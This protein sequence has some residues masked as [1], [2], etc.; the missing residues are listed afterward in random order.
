MLRETLNYRVL[1]KADELV[2]KV[3][4]I[5]NLHGQD[6]DRITKQVKDNELIVTGEKTIVERTEGLGGTFTYCTL[7][8]PIELDAILTGKDLPSYD[9]LGSVLY[10]MATNRTLESSAIRQSD[11]HLGDHGDQHVWLI[12]KPD[13]EWL[14]GPDAALTLGF[15]RKL[16]KD[17][18]NKDHLVFAASR[19]VS[20]KLLGEEGLRVEFVP[21]PFALYRI[22]KS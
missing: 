1:Q 19:F 13:L 22:E 15:A 3:N 14:K 11:F 2:Q 9:A 18:P 12:Y 20:E 6:Y 16:A 8:E 7:G 21:L 5:E 4:A 17:H 10:H